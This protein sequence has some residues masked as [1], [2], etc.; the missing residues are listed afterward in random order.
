VERV[1]RKV[2]SLALM[3]AHQV[4]LIIGSNLE[5]LEIRTTSAKHVVSLFRLRIILGHSDARTMECTLGQD[6]DLK[7]SQSIN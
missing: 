7:F 5:R 1:Y 6:Y 3:D 2:A 4:G